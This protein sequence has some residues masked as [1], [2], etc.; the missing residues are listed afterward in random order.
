[1]VAGES[2]RGWP[3]RSWVATQ[4]EPQF[5]RGLRVWVP[6]AMLR[7]ST[8]AQM[9]VHVINAVLHV[10]DHMARW[11]VQVGDSSLL[12]ARSVLVQVELPKACALTRGWLVDG[13]AK[14]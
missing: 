11:T 14:L 4:G 10:V 12:D 9:W 5:W 6:R 3:P 8:C 1:M 7:V 13:E 2:H